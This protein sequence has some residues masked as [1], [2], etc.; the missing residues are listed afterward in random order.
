MTKE[1][2]KKLHDDSPGTPTPNM[3]VQVSVFITP[4][5]RVTQL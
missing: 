1:N 4:T 2:K 5:D 3:E